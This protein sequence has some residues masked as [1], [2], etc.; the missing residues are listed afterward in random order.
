MGKSW[1]IYFD[2][3]SG[4]A[5]LRNADAAVERDGICPVAIIK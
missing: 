5:T 2:F 4:L 3:A 1:S